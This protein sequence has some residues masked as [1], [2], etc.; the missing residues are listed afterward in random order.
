MA[1]RRTLL[2]LGLSGLLGAL[3]FA[4]LAWTQ[5]G[6]GG[7]TTM[8]P[9]PYPTATPGGPAPTP[10]PVVITASGISFT[11][12]NVTVPSGTSIK[13]NTPGHTVDI[14]DGSGGGI[15]GGTDFTSFP[16]SFVFSGASGTVFHIHCDIHSSCG[17]GACSGCTGMVMAV[18]IQ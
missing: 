13:F 4:A 2:H 16:A 12:S 7:S 11:P 18:H 15:C 8:G 5:G 1:R 14:D 9:S 6:C 10:T 17:A 3:L